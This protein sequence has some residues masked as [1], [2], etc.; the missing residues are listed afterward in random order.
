MARFCATW[1][2]RTTTDR[3]PAEETSATSIASSSLQEQN[4]KLKRGLLWQ[5]A[6]RLAEGFD[7]L[8]IS[9]FVPPHRNGSR[10][11]ERG[12]TRLP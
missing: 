11:Q 7:D 4:E 9:T 1:D 12:C 5:K 10:F 3:N 2:A 8:Q 6:E